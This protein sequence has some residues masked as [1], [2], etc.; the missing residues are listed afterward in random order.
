[1]PL[2]LNYNIDIFLNLLEMIDNNL[3]VSICR[4]KVDCQITKF[5]VTKLKQQVMPTDVIQDVI[6]NENTYTKYTKIQLSQQT[7]VFF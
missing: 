4:V 3:N 5:K 2:I 7:S 6:Q 1:M